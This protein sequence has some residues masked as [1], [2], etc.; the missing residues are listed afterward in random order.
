MI[1]KLTKITKEDIKKDTQK[2]V[3]ETSM[4]IM[5]LH[6]NGIDNFQWDKKDFEKVL[7]EDIE[8]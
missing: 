1:L 5:Y 2:A 6:N 4:Q 8:E 7:E 3:N